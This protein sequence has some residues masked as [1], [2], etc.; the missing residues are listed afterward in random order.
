MKVETA[1]IATTTPAA[2]LGERPYLSLVIPAY[3]EEER[4]GP[5]LRA[6]V[7]AL[8]PRPFASEVL[9]VLDGC[10]DGTAAVAAAAAGP[11][12][13][14]EVRVL[15]RAERR[16]K[17]AS[18]REGM[19]AARGAFRVFTDADLSYPLEHLDALL[20]ALE[21]GAGLAI[22]SRD[23]SITRYQRPLRRLVTRLSRWVMHTLVVPGISDTQAGFKGFTAPVA[24]DLFAVQR[25]SGFG[26]DVELLHVAR[27]RGYRIEAIAMEW[28]DVPGSKVRLGRDVTR[29]ALELLAM[30]GHR[31]AGRYAR[32]PPEPGP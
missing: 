14:C 5:T 8:A 27:L 20:V 1:P 16:G 19:L 23:A 12:G 31:L 15:A 13:A 6:V 22:A 11:V 3:N 18:V 30:Y 2:A 32:R 28:T 24:Q 17:G 9:V 29:M 25:L 26:F 10:T 7:A 4:L 21:G